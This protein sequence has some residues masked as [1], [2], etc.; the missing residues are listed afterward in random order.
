MNEENQNDPNELR[1][2]EEMILEDILNSAINSFV[3]RDG[4]K[5][6]LS[7]RGINVSEELYD[8]LWQFLDY[9][10]ED[11]IHI[12]GLIEFMRSQIEQDYDHTNPTF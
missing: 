2:F 11:Q 6:I 7:N 9:Q 5:R 3:T 4:L 10:N 12:T 1:D 8:K